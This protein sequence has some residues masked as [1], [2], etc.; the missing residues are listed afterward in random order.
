MKKLNVIKFAPLNEQHPDVRGM[1]DETLIPFWHI[2]QDVGNCEFTAC[3]HAITEYKIKQKVGKVT[4][5]NCLEIIKFYKEL[6]K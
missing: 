4:C 2:I 3:G 5:P 6:G 1:L